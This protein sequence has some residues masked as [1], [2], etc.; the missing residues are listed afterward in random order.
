[1]NEE[2]Y[3]TNFGD[4]EIAAALYGNDVIKIFSDKEAP[5]GH[6]LLVDPK[7]HDE[8]KKNQVSKFLDKTIN[9]GKFGSSQNPATELSKLSRLALIS[10]C[11]DFAANYIQLLRDNQVLIASAAFPFPIKF[12]SKNK[13]FSKIDCVWGDYLPG[14]HSHHSP[15]YRISLGKGD[16]LILSTDGIW[17]NI[18]TALGCDKRLLDGVRD[19]ENEEIARQDSEHLGKKVK[20]QHIN[21]IKARNK[22]L[23]DFFKSNAHKSAY[24]IVDTFTKTLGPM[25][26]PKT[27]DDDDA[28]IV[29]IKKN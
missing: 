4:Y 29:V 17:E 21:I 23:E 7:G 11:P 1:M 13:S 24:K 28:T 9:N 5:R 14:Y 26:I 25:F 12:K 16:L 22:I 27:E 15:G 3:N 18:E 20:D 6:I 10:N 8:K 19:Q 2:K